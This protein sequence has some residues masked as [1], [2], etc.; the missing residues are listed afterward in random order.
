MPIVFPPELMVSVSGFRGKVGHP[1]T[2]ELITPLAAG[3]GA[4]LK[5]TP[6]GTRFSWDGT[7]G[8]PGPCSPEARPPAS[9]P[10]VAT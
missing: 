1:L 4:F 8:P 10:W 9:S 5:Q 7:P 2:P 6:D 3:F